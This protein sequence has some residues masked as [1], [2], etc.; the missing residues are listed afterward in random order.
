[1]YLGVV[2]RG[3]F[4]FFKA[5]SLSILHS[6]PSAVGVVDV[7]GPGLINSDYGKRM[8]ICGQGVTRFLER[9]VG[10]TVMGVGKTSL[11]SGTQ[12]RFSFCSFF[13]CF[14]RSHFSH[15]FH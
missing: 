3:I 13:S 2:G 10:S 5:F 8:Q 6:F 1:M 7:S 12:C 15:I 4:Y 14:F 9:W 11:E